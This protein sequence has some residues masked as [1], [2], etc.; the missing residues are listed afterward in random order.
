[1]QKIFKRIWSFGLAA[2]MCLGIAAVA[3]G[4]S[5][6]VIIADA[7][8]DYY[9]AITATGGNDLLGQVHDLITTT[10][11]KYTSY[12]DCKN[13]TYVKKT[14]PG[15][16]GQLM[17][18]YAQANLS[19]T[20]QSG[21]VG[22]WNRE[23]VW[24]QSLS[25]GMWGTSG[26][27]S[28]LHHI[29][30]TES[31]VNSTRGNNRYGKANNGKEAW[32]KDA[33]GA[34]IALAGYYV[35]NTIFEPLDNVKGDVARI[36]MYVY[37]HYNSYGNVNG[38]T[39]GNGSSNYFG[40]LQFSS[41]MYANSESAAIELLL[42]WN[43]LDPV[44]EIETTRNDAVY[45]IQGNRNPFIDHPEY[46]DAI[47][48]DGTITP[49]PSVELK[50][51]SLNK[52]SLT[53]SE[54][55]SERLTV[56][57]NPSN[58]SVS[59]DWSSS[60]TAVAIVSA[61][62]EVTAKAV[63]TATIT[64]TCKANPSIKA[65]A[66]V[67][68]E[69]SQSKIITITT[70]SFTLSS[71]YGFQTWSE[72]G[73]SGTAFIYGGNSAS[74]QFNKNKSSYYLASTTAGPGAIK[75]VTV[76]ASSESKADRDWKLLTSDTPYGEVEGK[77]T[78]GNDQGTKTVTEQGVTWTVSGSDTYF[79]LTYEFPTGT[80]SAAAYL[81]SIEVEYGKEDGGQEE[82][83][84][85]HV[86]EICGECT[87]ETCTDP[88]CADKCEGHSGEEENTKL[89]EFHAAVEG[90]ITSGSLES[91]FA[92]INRAITAY[93]ALSDE[94]KALAEED[95]AALRAA[96]DEYNKTV[97]SYNEEAKNANH[98]AGAIRG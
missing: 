45:A 57:P 56:T 39:N 11:T 89:Q 1:M 7:A 60:N 19:S 49:D 31:R 35:G 12:D 6:E 18:F 3:N 97:N 94:E 30:P 36:V 22:T 54:G 64:A 71:S 87:D 88:V 73:V 68:V 58:A 24:C 85:G 16:D 29:R 40:K 75:S 62:G 27:G 67:T 51:I 90:I 61:S 4:A 96:I 20:W 28:D 47:W 92:S 32:Y 52:T 38:T 53:L 79:A 41:I 2:L 86:C 50:S 98:A 42:Q 33:S 70:N 8:T 23:H 66:Q 83:I 81:E 25:N 65:T 26:G 74:M 43:A 55:R 84:C 14:D 17:E 37:T 76:K 95:I 13:P 77:P 91:R 69:K 5:A 10:H 82:H 59:V 21:A 63:G 34:S 44:D 78:N 93:Q 48:G 80:Q 15:T 72:G 46:A 9:A